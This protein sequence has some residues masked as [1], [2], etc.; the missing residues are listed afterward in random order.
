MSRVRPL[1][2]V[3]RKTAASVAGSFSA[4]KF[5]QLHINPAQRMIFFYFFHLSDLAADAMRCP[6]FINYCHKNIFSS[7]SAG[8]TL[9]SLITEAHALS[10]EAAG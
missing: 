9:P 4:L 6:S 2:A 7:Q 10:W 8:L 1:S 3:S 5:L